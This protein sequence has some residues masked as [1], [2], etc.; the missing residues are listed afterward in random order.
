M[1]SIPQ[2]PIACGTYGRIAHDMVIVGDT[3]TTGLSPFASAGGNTAGERLCSVGFHRL[4]R[5]KSGWTNEDSFSQLVNPLCPVPPEASAVNGFEWVPDG[6]ALEDGKINLAGYPTFD[7]VADEMMS[8]IG[9]APLVFHNSAFDLA[10]LDAE[11]ARLGH[12]ALTANPIICTK[13][14]FSDML[15]KGRP[16]SYVSG[17]NLNRLCETLGVDNSE[18]FDPETGKELHGA[19]IDAKM[20]ANCFAIL[21]PFGW[22]KEEDARIF[23]HHIEGRLNQL[24]PDTM[25]AEP[26]GMGML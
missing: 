17:T 7:E 14:A 13:Q 19:L 10:F 6:G 8:Y 16:M 9:S 25:S 2:S 21:E 11:L 15:G 20:A 26:A 24:K 3:E 4:V 12:G 18:R 1:S 23:P 5:T 22:M